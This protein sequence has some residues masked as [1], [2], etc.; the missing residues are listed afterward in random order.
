ML[1]TPAYKQSIHTAKEQRGVVLVSALLILLVVMILAATAFQTSYVQTLV[2][3]NFRF[4]KI[5]FNNA[6]STLRKAENVIDKMVSTGEYFNYDGSDNRYYNVDQP[7]DI[8]AVNWDEIISDDN[9][10][11]KFIIQY[12]GR[13]EIPGA[14]EAAEGAPGAIIGSYVYVFVVTARSLTPKG[15]E[16]VVQSVY[17]TSEQ[18]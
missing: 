11:N 5:S 6:E 8:T 1:L 17:V 4:Q 9:S 10:A 2:A 16:R 14:D 7:V 12:Q 3:N 18:L 15:A 13:Q